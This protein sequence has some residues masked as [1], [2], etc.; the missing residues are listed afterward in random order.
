MLNIMFN[1]MTTEHRLDAI[2]WENG[3]SLSCLFAQPKQY[4][5]AGS[6]ARIELSTPLRM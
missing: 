1:A 4:D 5:Y 3:S 2:R 6:L